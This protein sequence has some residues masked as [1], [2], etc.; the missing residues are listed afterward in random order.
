MNQ[1]EIFVLVGKRIRRAIANRITAAGVAIVPS[2]HGPIE[3]S[4]W[5]ATIAEAQA[6]VSAKRKWS[7]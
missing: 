7:K 2:E 1:I 4:E 3:F 6:A 5:F